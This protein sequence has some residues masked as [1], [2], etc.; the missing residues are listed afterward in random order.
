MSSIADG[1]PREAIIY[2]VNHP[3]VNDRCELPDL[4][5]YL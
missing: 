2:A 5:V 3:D 1:K 4:M